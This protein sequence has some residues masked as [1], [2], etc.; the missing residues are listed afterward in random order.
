MLPGITS[1]DH[2]LSTR[3]QFQS[4]MPSVN[5]PHSS[6]HDTSSY[7]QFVECSL[8]TNL[9]LINS[10]FHN[11]FWAEFLGLRG[12]CFQSYLFGPS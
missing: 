2:K 7:A 8:H 1:V 9:T 3:K 5:S 11:F 10:H 6:A 4:L 12:Y